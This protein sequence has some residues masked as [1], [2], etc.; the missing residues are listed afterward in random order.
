MSEVEGAQPLKTI[1]RD[2]WKVEQARLNYQSTG[3]RAGVEFLEGDASALVAALTGPFDCMFFDADRLSA[4]EQLRLLLPKLSPDV[5]LLCDNVLSHP[6]Q[7][8]S[9][10]A[11]VRA[12][13]LFSEVTV[14]VGKGLHLA[15]RTAY[16]HS[17]R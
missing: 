5:M 10:L 15:H 11:A 8:A 12:L 6:G 4:P 17:R 9:Y 14:P 16:A 13:P 3:L 1:E 2:H 7:V